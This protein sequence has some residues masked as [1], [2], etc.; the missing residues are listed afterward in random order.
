MSRGLRPTQ[1]FAR[2]QTRP[3]RRCARGFESD[4]GSCARAVPS[5]QTVPAGPSRVSPPSSA[6]S[7]TFTAALLCC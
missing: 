3:R 2:A 5:P 4:L 6:S 7:C 1:A